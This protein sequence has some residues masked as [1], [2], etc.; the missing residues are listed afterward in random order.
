MF[1]AGILRR[2]C[3][4]GTALFY[5]D[6][7]RLPYPGTDLLVIACPPQSTKVP[8]AGTPH[9]L[10]VDARARGVVSIQQYV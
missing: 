8:D 6:G 5:V 1:E 4:V 9:W 3:I 10:I 2:V 7:R